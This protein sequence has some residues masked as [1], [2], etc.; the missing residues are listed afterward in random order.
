[1]G[2][3]IAIIAANCLCPLI[4]IVIGVV[5]MVR[6]GKFRSGI[7]YHTSMSQKNEQTWYTAQVFFAKA[8]VFSNI[9][10][11]ALSAAFTVIS[12]LKG[13]DDKEEVGLMIMV[14]SI[15]VAVL[16]CDIFATEKHLRSRFDKDGNP[17]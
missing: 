9:P 10:V 2:D 3:N 4:V 12:V 17:K 13:L 1:M 15:Q 8:A 16:L 14:T 11:L 5:M 7:G 6:P